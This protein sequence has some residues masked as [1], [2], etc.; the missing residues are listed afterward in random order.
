MVDGQHGF[1]SSVRIERARSPRI[2]RATETRLSSV[3]T[4]AALARAILYDLMLESGQGAYWCSP[5]Q[6]RPTGE[7]RWLGLESGHVRD[8]T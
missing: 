2:V 5:A 1:S 8:T 7:S 4:A 6:H 3:I